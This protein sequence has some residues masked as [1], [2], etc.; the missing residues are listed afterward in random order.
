M[1]GPVGGQVAAEEPTLGGEDL[2]LERVDRGAVDELPEAQGPL[3][4]DRHGQRP[5][6]AGIAGAAGKEAAVQDHA[7]ADEPADE[8][9][10]EIEILAAIAEDELRRAGGGGVVAK[11]HRPGRHRRD[12]GR[13][14]ERAPALHRAGAARS[15]SSSQF[16]NSNGIA[17]PVPAIR[18]A[19]TPAASRRML[20]LMKAM[21]EPGRG[22]AVGIARP[23]PDRAGEVHED[24]VGAPPA[25]LDAERQ[26][27][28]RVEGER[29][30]RLPDLAAPAAPLDHQPVG[31]ERRA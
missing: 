15:T 5:D 22:I 3:A 29:H 2:P 23:L 13:D 26:R 9:V 27:A 18:S 12:L 11:V 28:I 30:R 25:D 17:T 6:G 8:D 7:A 20:S 31:L 14:V 10:E 16:H 19:G 24:D 1:P 21:T 4:G